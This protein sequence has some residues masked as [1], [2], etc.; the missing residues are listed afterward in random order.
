MTKPVNEGNRSIRGMMT[1]GLPKAAMAVA[2]FSGSGLLA[3]MPTMRVRVAEAK[4]IDAPAAITLVGTVEPLRRSRVSSEIA[5]IVKEMPARQGDRVEAGGVLCVLDSVALS[6]RLGEARARLGALSARHQEWIAGTRAEELARLKALVDE[7]AAEHDR[8]KFEMQRVER[9]YEGR[10]AHEKEY[11]DTR[12]QLIAAEQRK[13]AAQAAYEMGVNGARKETLVHAAFEVAEQQSVVD[14]LESDLKK[15]T[16]RAPFTGFVVHR[17]TEVGEWVNDG[18]AIVEMVDIDRVLVRV[19]VPESALV[20][21]KVGAPS[22]VQVDAAKQAFQGKIRHMIRQGDPRA[23]TFPVEVEVENKDL[24]L[25]GGMF[26]RVTVPSGPPVS[27]VVVPKDSV[28]DRDGIAHVGLVVPGPQGGLVGLLSPVTVGADVEDWISITSGN[29]APGTR[30]VTHGNE[31]L[32][33]FPTP[34]ECVDINGN[35]LKPDAVKP[36]EAKKPV[37]AEEKRG[38][39]FLHDYDANHLAPKVLCRVNPEAR[40]A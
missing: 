14:R 20:F 6:H 15:T 13:A 8:W 35:L 11:T 32:Q 22:R 34:V 16:V 26:A 40:P 9:L 28:M 27:V 7:A 39:A 33:T 3:Q 29:V 12:S 23:R 18:G 1:R 5:G 38:D 21:A 24:I 4:L 25:A 17:A 37:P 2:I 31:A 36:S 10:E 30:V 19:D